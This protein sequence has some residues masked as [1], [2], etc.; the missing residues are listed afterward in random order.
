MEK[1]KTRLKALTPRFCH[2]ISDGSG[3]LSKYHVEFALVQHEKMLLN[4]RKKIFGCY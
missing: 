1:R 3:D 2:I 4:V